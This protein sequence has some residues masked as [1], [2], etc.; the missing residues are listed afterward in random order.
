MARKHC[1]EGGRA[2]DRCIEEV[3]V[4]R[5]DWVCEI[6]THRACGPL[7][8]G[9]QGPPAA[10]AL[11]PS[12]AHAATLH[13]GSSAG[14]VRFY[15]IVRGCAG[16]LVC[17]FAEKTVIPTTC[18]THGGS[19]RG[20]SRWAFHSSTHTQWTQTPIVPADPMARVA[21]TGTAAAEPVADGAGAQAPATVVLPGRCA[22]DAGIAP[23]ARNWRTR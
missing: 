21:M 19:G 6:S 9:E 5:R 1:G 23:I 18:V 15:S 14:S 7:C 3:R 12:V 11:L 13:D 10:V 17:M 20:T 2:V 4:R 22:A 8:L 16:R